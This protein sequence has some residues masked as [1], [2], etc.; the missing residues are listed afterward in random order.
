MLLESKE[1]IG[2]LQEKSV[3]LAGA[4]ITASSLFL[5]GSR[6]AIIV[7]SLILGGIIIKHLGKLKGSILVSILLLGTILI[8]INTP[9]LNERF[10]KAI[11]MFTHSALDVNEYIVDDRLMTWTNSLELIKEEPITG[12]NIGD[13]RFSILSEKHNV[14]GFGKGYRQKLNAHNQLFENWLALGI[15]GL[16]SV[17]SIY[18][19]AG[20]SSIKNHELI[21]GKFLVISF[22]FSMVESIFQSQGGVMFFGFFMAFFMHFSNQE[23]IQKKE[24]MED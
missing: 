22:M 5:L 19:F 17:L 18:L 10:S 14:S 8:T 11:N 21:F 23:L 1:T 9:F 3:K 12:Y 15:I 4:I 7:L 2:F 16:L 13:Y 20:Y 24:K 6:M